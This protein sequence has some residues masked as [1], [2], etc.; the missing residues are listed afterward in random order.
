VEDGSDFRIALWEATY[1][2]YICP[3]LY[4]L[5]FRGF[6]IVIIAESIDPAP[7]PPEN[8]STMAPGIAV[9]GTLGSP[10]DVARAKVLLPRVL[11]DS[12][13]FIVRLRSVAT[14]CLVNEGN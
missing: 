4:R 9:V 13:R 12:V 7:L 5:H 10:S 14:Y 2:L 6:S 11:G 3:F 1:V 8:E